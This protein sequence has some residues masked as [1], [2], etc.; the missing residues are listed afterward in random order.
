M[1]VTYWAN[2][3]SAFDDQIIVYFPELFQNSFIKS[4]RKIFKFNNVNLISTSIISVKLSVIMP[5]YNIF[6]SFS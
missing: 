6:Y 3:M 4:L 2:L 1:S 5:F